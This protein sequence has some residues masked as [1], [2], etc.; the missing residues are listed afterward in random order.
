MNLST[1]LASLQ[2]EKETQAPPADPPGSGGSTGGGASPGSPAEGGTTVTDPSQDPSYLYQQA[3]YARDIHKGF[4][5]Y[6]GRPPSVKE[7]ADWSNQLTLA[8]GDLTHLGKYL[9]EHSEFL[10]QYAG[11][12]LATAVNKVYQNVLGRS[13]TTNE[14]TD[15]VKQVQDGLPPTHIPWKVLGKALEA[16]SA[17]NQVALTKLLV[18]EEFTRV[19]KE[20]GSSTGTVGSPSTGNP[21]S[22]ASGS[23]TTGSG[24][25]GAAGEGSDASAAYNFSNLMAKEAARSLLSEIKPGSVDLI[26]SVQK[27]GLILQKIEQGIAPLWPEVKLNI[28]SEGFVVDGMTTASKVTLDVSIDKNAFAWVERGGEDGRF[29]A[30]VDLRV[31]NGSITVPL[32]LGE[33]QIKVYQGIGISASLPGGMTIFRADPAERDQAPPDVAET[34]PI[35]RSSTVLGLPFSERIN[36]GAFD[37]NTD[38]VLE[39][40]ELPM[41]FSANGDTLGFGAKVIAAT[42]NMLNIELGYRAQFSEGGSIVLL[43]VPDMAGNMANLT[44]SL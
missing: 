14:L 6:L 23:T 32:A 21:S 33:N 39:V 11:M 3:Q 36:W 28:A 9:F 2:K 5:A 4:I 29:D 8:K 44:F 37:A 25:T 41:S 16:G 7:L 38:G 17:D 24:G 43:G 42:G 1:Y 30:Y 20:S 26:G 31:K 15:W 12:S 22:P 10:F 27:I 40:E 13:A 34:N 19:L 18:G 35:L